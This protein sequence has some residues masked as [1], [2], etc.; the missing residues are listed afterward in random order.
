MHL[1]IIVFPSYAITHSCGP[2]LATVYSFCSYCDG[3]LY[4]K[5]YKISHNGVG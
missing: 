2:L 5:S 3:G 4:H 1:C